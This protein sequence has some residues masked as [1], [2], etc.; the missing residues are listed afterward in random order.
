MKLNFCAICGE[1]EDLKHHHFTPR[2]HGGSDDETNLL[3]LCH[4]HHCQIHGMSYRNNINHGKLVAEGLQRAKERGVKLGS[5]GACNVKK[6]NKGK[7]AAAEQ[8]SKKLEYVIKPLRESGKTY[9]FIADTLNEM[10]IQ[11]PQGKCFYPASVRN[12][13]LRFNVN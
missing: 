6:A 5:A 9:Q 3:T 10:G 12:Y 8:F 7:I 13:T 11:T 4:K 1:T 2:I